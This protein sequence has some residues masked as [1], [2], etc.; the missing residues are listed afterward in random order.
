MVIVRA[1]LLCFSPYVPLSGI[2]WRGERCISKVC[3]S[4]SDVPKRSE[5]W[6]NFRFL[7]NVCAIAT[8]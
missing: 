3:P 4:S 7:D 6:K 1:P 5:S 2:K 8:L